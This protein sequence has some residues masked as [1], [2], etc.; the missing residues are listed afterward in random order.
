MLRLAPGRPPVAHY[1]AAPK[2]RA[3]RSLDV[4]LIN[5]LTVLLSVCSI[6][7]CLGGMTLAHNEIV[8]SR[9][10]ALLFALSGLVGLGAFMGAALV[11]VFT[12]HYGAALVGVAGLMPLVAVTS[13][14]FAAFQHPAINDVST[15]VTNPPAFVQAPTLPENAGR[16]LKF[17]PEN[18]ELVQ[19]HYAELKPLALNLAP[20]QAYERALAIAKTH[21]PE[22]S[23][24]RE[25]PA[26]L[27]F[28]GVAISKLFRWRSDFI[29]RARP[30]AD[31]GA[32]LDM[33]ARAREGRSDLGVNA[34]RIAQYFA[35]IAEL[36]I[37]KPE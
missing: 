35:E 11:L 24:T 17:P 22:W 4:T 18:V 3:W 37:A 1:V 10:G 30:G 5:R 28:E 9:T 15:D 26:N 6:A 21:A 14:V 12:R 7:L 34:R 23:I 16:D 36:D 27:T 19:R 2:A 32:L 20:P 33:R 31:G 13:T 8:A 29:V 25:D